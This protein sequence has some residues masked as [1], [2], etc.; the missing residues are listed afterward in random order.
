MIKDKS[1]VTAEIEEIEPRTA[2][3]GAPM[4]V[5]SLRVSKGDYE[6]ERMWMNMVFTGGATAISARNLRELGY[7]GGLADSE[8]M[9]KDLV[10]TE[11]EFLVKHREYNGETRYDVSPK[12]TGPVR[13]DESQKNEWAV[14]MTGALRMAG[15]DDTDEEDP[16]V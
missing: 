1:V 10:G 6:G 15:I 5:F 2:K 9:V 8:R 11:H 13:L 12:G 3:S 4:L 14:A 7:E 16:F